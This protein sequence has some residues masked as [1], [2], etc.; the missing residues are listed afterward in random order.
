MQSQCID[1]MKCWN[2]C[3]VYFLKQYF[4]TNWPDFCSFDIV[5]MILKID[6]RRYTDKDASVLSLKNKT[7]QSKTT[8]R[9]FDLFKIFSLTITSFLLIFF[10][11]GSC[12]MFVITVYG[13]LPQS[14]KVCWLKFIKCTLI[15]FKHNN[16]LILFL[17]WWIFLAHFWVPKQVV[18][19][20]PY[21]IWFLF[22]LWF[23]QSLTLN[24]IGYWTQEREVR[25]SSKYQIGDNI[26]NRSKAPQLF[27]VIPSIT[28]H[29]FF[30]LIKNFS[31]VYL[32]T[33]E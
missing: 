9:F 16:R 22:I 4:S 7:K 29:V 6:I 24:Q 31:P 14:D 19:V 3:F 27:C 20:F 26:Y 23:L 2:W 11:V 10:S 32:Y 33:W 15:Y 25:S 12:K 17:N 1:K 28:P 18:L 21:Q 5:Y 13:I 8:E 30:S